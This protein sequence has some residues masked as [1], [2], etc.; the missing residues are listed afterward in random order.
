MNEFGFSERDWKL[1]RSKVPGWQEAYM[2]RLNREYIELLSGG[3]NPADRFWALDKRIRRDKRGVGVVI[4]MRRS[5][6]WENIVALI[7]DGVI[8]LND[9]DDFS[10]DVRERVRFL[11]GGFPS[12]K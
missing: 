10:E 2:D 3:G 4:D 7:C 11:F 6:F 1:F 9:L 8:D 12:G 5:M